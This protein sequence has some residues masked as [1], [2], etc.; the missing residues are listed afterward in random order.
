MVD[1]EKSLFGDADDSF[2]SK[3]DDA[4]FLARK[5]YVFEEDAPEAEE[6]AGSVDGIKFGLQGEAAYSEDAM[7]GEAAFSEVAAKQGDVV[8][9]KMVDAVPKGTG[10]TKQTKCS[11][12]FQFTLNEV[13]K[14]DA[15]KAY[16]L[17]NKQIRYILA[18]KELAPSTKK[19]HIHC[20]VQ[21]D[22][23][24]GPILAKAAETSPIIDVN[25][26]F[27]VTFKDKNG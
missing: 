16:L 26:D 5:R 8:Y 17:S 9:Q 10:R 24:A 2:I 3:H 11:S 6:S 27:Y 13:E 22:S 12:A 4:S 1:A 19:E 25:F 21:I 23:Q 7:Q 18:V 15:L 20:Y 14:W